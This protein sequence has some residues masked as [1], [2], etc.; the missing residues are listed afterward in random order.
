MSR[1][2][3]A[4]YA[5]S[6]AP[7]VKT[8]GFGMTPSDTLRAN[9]GAVRYRAGSVCFRCER[10]DPHLRFRCRRDQDHAHQYQQRPYDRARAD[11]FPA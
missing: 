2:C 4:L 3:P 7:L 1:R 5:R 6:L 10:V 11:R 8:R 9:S